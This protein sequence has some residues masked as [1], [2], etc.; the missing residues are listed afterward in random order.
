M[1]FRVLARGVLEEL[2]RYGAS[3]TAI[4]TAC[5][6]FERSSDAGEL[7]GSLRK[8]ALE[9]HLLPQSAAA[10]AVKADALLLLE[11]LVGELQ[12]QRMLY[13]RAQQ[14]ETPVVQMAALSGQQS[15]Q[16]EQVIYVEV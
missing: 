10:G 16:L 9:L 11:I 14:E 3:T 15:T 7:L 12:A 13:H 1:R 6:C 5:G 8:V 4:V 2:R